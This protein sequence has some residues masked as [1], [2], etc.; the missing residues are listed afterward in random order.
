MGCDKRDVEEKASVCSVLE[1]ALLCAVLESSWCLMSA[2]RKIAVK[3]GQI[4][5]NIS[6]SFAFFVNAAM[7]IIAAAVFHFGKNK[8][9]NVADITTAYKLLE[10]ALGDKVAPKLFAVALLCSGQQSTITGETLCRLTTLQ[11]R[12]DTQRSALVFLS[13]L[14]L[15]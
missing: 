4:D 15:Q 11:L 14:H 1:Q 8:N 2:G 12:S 6:L 10:P 9:T 3:Y 7:L 5:S 13:S